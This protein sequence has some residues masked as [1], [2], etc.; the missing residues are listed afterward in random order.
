MKTRTIVL[1]SVLG[2]LVGLSLKAT[3]FQVNLVLGIVMAAICTIILFSWSINELRKKRG[4][5]GLVATILFF[6]CF[7]A[8]LSVVL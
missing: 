3:F 1:S 7:L 5:S 2:F 8:G 4:S 6:V